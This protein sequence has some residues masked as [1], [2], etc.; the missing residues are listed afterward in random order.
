MNVCAA[1]NF[2]RHFFSSEKKKR[3]SANLAVQD[4]RDEEKAALE[5]AKKRYGAIANKK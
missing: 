5:A 1:Q 3:H 2:S 4:C